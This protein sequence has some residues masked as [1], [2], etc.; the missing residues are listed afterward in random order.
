MD[1]ELVGNCFIAHTWSGGLSAQRSCMLGRPTCRS[2]RWS[3]RLTSGLVWMPTS[4]RRW[5]RR[6]S[7]S[8]PTK[9]SSSK[10]SEEGV[11]QDR[12]VDRVDSPW[13]GHASQ[14]TARLTLDCLHACPPCSAS[15]HMTSLQHGISWRLSWNSAV[16]WQEEEAGEAGSVDAGRCKRRLGLHRITC[17][18]GDMILTA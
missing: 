8:R 11:T 4:S 10:T 15:S 17:C 12:H 13:T 1:L 3:C 9:P 6:A 5:S 14:P 2:R 18:D 7:G 16:S